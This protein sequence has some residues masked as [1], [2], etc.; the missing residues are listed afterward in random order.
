MFP[1]NKILT[2]L[3]F[4][5]YLMQKWFL[6]PNSSCTWRKRELISKHDNLQVFASWLTSQSFFFPP[7]FLKFCS[8]GTEGKPEFS[9]GP[10]LVKLLSC[11][12]SVGHVLYSLFPQPI[13]WPCTATLLL[14]TRRSKR[15]RKILPLAEKAN[16]PLHW[17]EAALQND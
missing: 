8:T 1:S 2:D 7:S 13:S 17:S 10:G 6:D 16:Q 15:T 5:L 14:S 11:G 9:C 3:F 12:G 4:F